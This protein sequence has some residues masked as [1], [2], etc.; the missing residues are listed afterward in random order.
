[1]KPCGVCG[2]SSCYAQTPTS[3]RE[4]PAVLAEC[5][6]LGFGRVS[7]E[8]A[9]LQKTVGELEHERGE[10]N[11]ALKAELAANTRLTEERNALAKDRAEAYQRTLEEQGRRARAEALNTP[12]RDALRSAADALAFIEA[13]AASSTGYAQTRTLRRSL[14]GIAREAKQHAAAARSRLEKQPAPAPGVDV[15]AADNAP[16][17]KPQATGGET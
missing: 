8:N 5:F 2:R 9:R 1:V 3:N 10:M 11:E 14:A 6:R 7:G 16:L 17:R 12:L 15:T 4:R 13:D